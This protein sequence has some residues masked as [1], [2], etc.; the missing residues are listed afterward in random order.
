MRD[1]VDGHP[2]REEQL[3]YLCAQ[4]HTCACVHTHTRACSDLKVLCEGEGSRLPSEMCGYQRLDSPYVSKKA[5]HSKVN[6]ET[7]KK[8]N[9]KA[10]RTWRSW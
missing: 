5:P 6:S 1:Q 4:M 7:Q 9:V 8:P 2:V 10:H 3:S